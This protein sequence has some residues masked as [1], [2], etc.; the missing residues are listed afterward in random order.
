MAL[1]SLG[2]KASDQDLWDMVEFA[3]ADGSGELDFVEFC[4]MLEQGGCN[5]EQAKLVD[6]RRG[7]RWLRGGGVDRW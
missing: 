6:V 1:R 2:F 4:A 5:H 3:D 7:A